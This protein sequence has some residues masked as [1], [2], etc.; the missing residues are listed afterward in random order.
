M[1]YRPLRANHS[2][3]SDEANLSHAHCLKLIDKANALI[4]QMLHLPM[5]RLRDTFVDF[6]EI[7]DMLPVSCKDVEEHWLLL[8]AWSALLE[9]LA[10]GKSGTTLTTARCELVASTAALL[11][12][13]DERVGRRETYFH[14]L[15]RQLS[16]LRRLD[17]GGL[18]AFG[19]DVS[20]CIKLIRKEFRP[21]QTLPAMRKR[22]SKTS[23][24]GTFLGGLGRPQLVDPI[25]RL[26]AHPEPSRQVQRVVNEAR[27][28]NNSPVSDRELER[29]RANNRL[30]MAQVRRA[31]TSRD[32]GQYFGNG[33]LGHWS[34]PVSHL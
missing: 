13:S 24:N 10:R 19:A 8:D 30:Y 1:D 14:L 2:A 21:N 7:A 25:W 4:T 34:N 15:E 12:I 27:R 32:E 5:S 20:F 31:A 23:P 18:P 11:A 22:R 17:F 9:A 16:C 29:I 3:H 26:K 28:T 6:A 33:G